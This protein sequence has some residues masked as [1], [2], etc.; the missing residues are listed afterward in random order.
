[1]AI[2]LSPAGGVLDRVDDVLVAGAAA[3]IAGDAF[4]NLLLGGGGV[5]GE[6]ADRRHDHA[7]R[8]VAALEAVLLP[9]AF[10]HRMELAVGGEPFDGGDRAA[11]GLDRE[12]RAGLDAAAVHMD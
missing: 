12:H 5:V 4:A 8:A 10:L 6:K 7:R 1:M 9:E 11:V 2:W 3:Q